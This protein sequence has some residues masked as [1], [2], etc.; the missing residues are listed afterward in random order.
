MYAPPA[1]ENFW[2]GLQKNGIS[3]GCKSKEQIFWED[4]KMAEMGKS[5]ISSIR[6]GRS[7]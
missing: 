6:L 7:R 4:W 5:K 2:R 1:D 3:E